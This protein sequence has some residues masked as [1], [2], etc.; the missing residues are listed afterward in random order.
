MSARFSSHKPGLPEPARALTLW[1]PLGIY[2][3]F[4]LLYAV[5][6]DAWE[7]M[8]AKEGGIEWLAVICLFVGVGFGLRILVKHR[9]SLPSVGLVWWFG[10]ATLG[11][12]VF[13]GEEMSW[14]QHLGFWSGED[15]PERIRELNAQDETNLHNMHNIMN[16]V[17]MY[18]IEIGTIVAFVFRPIL[19]R[20]ERL[21]RPVM[22]W[23]NPG[24][25]FWPTSAC[26]AAAVGVLLIRQPERVVELVSGAG[27]P[28]V[29]HQSELH[30][31][32]IALLMTTYMV[33]VHH[34]LAGYAADAK[35]QKDRK[36]VEAAL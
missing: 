24:Y 27:A 12:F 30:E 2:L 3:L 11:M 15:I 7:I 8:R 34:R 16:R 35:H 5:W 33:S 18:A 14:G 6:P 23:D 36:E 29:L 25:W 13:A 1:A 4:F 21:K 31:F 26:T 32:Y 9:H 17:P 10:L 20:F 22:A 19:Q 28:E